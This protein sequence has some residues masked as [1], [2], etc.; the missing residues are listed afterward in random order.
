MCVDSDTGSGVLR[1]VEIPTVDLIKVVDESSDVIELKSIGVRGEECLHQLECQQISPGLIPYRNC[2]VLA[3]IDNIC[4]VEGEL[5]V[6]CVV[7]HDPHCKVVF[8]TSI[9]VWAMALLVDIF[10]QRHVLVEGQSHRS[11]VF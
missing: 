6:D 9:L 2:V 4:W 10:L 7:E 3:N 8:P 5:T 1:H 11:F